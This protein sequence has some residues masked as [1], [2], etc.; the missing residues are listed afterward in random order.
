MFIDCRTFRSGISAISHVGAHTVLPLE[1]PGPS[2]PGAMECTGDWGMETPTPFSNLNRLFVITCDF[3]DL[4]Q[5]IG[6]KV[7]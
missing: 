3:L 5:I 6:V 1:L 2:T 4:V 7:M